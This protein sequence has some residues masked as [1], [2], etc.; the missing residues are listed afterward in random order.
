MGIFGIKPTHLLLKGLKVRCLEIRQGP[1]GW[2]VLI[3]SD[4]LTALIT[5]PLL[6]LVHVFLTEDSDSWIG[7]GITWFAHQGTEL[8]S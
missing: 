5:E 4:G 1:A 2:V 8:R 3:Q 6:E 7:L